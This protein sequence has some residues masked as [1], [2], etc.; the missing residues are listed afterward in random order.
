MNGAD[1]D[2]LPAGAEMDRLI[3]QNVMPMYPSEIPHYSA[4]IYLA[5]LV[6]GEMQKRGYWMRL[7]SPF[8]LGD[9]W[10]VGFTS[11]GASGWNGRPD[12]A[13]PGNTPALAICRAALRVVFEQPT[14]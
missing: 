1:I 3:A 14:L 10:R 12:Y 11:L 5:M 2:K 8:Y 9:T 6:Q 4:L 13:S 7:D